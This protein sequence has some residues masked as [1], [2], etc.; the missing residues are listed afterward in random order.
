MVGHVESSG[1]WRMM[2]E[3][4]GRAGEELKGVVKDVQR[5]DGKTA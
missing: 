5:R 2:A 1:K 4:I 3:K